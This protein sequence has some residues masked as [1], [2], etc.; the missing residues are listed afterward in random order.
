MSETRKQLE[1]SSLGFHLCGSRALGTHE[2]DSDWD[3]VVTD[4][5]IVCEFLEGLG[6]EPIGYDGHYDTNDTPTTVVMERSDAG[7]KIQVSVEVDAVYKRHIIRALARHAPLRELDKGLRTTPKLRDGLWHALYELAGWP[8]QH[9][10]PAQE[11]ELPL[12]DDGK[13]VAF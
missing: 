8:E 12:Y 10:A 11:A 13:D 4:G 2:A 1:A 9:K 6:F 7:E 3:Y 5:P